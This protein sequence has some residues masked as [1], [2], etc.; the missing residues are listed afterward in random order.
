MILSGTLCGWYYP[1]Y[2][3]ESHWSYRVHFG[4]MVLSP[5]IRYLAPYLEIEIVQNLHDPDLLHSG[6]R[7]ESAAGVHMSAY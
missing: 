2:H 6:L 5:Y 1:D 4:L 3:R 7:L